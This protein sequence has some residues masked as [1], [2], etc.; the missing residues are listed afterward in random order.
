MRLRDEEEEA[1]GYALPAWSINMMAA[2]QRSFDDPAVAAMQV[3][4]RAVK[5]LKS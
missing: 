2:N 4:P 3:V 5:A 1:R